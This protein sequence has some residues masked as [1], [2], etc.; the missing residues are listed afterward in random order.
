MALPKMQAGYMSEKVVG[1]KYQGV[2]LGMTIPLW[3]NKNQVKFA[4]A[5]VLAVQEMETDVKVILYNQ[6]KGL[7]AK[8]DGLR[9][10][11]ADYRLQ[12]ERFS[13]T[14]LLR[15]AL[16]KGEISLAEYIFELSQF[17]EG[18][19]NLLAMERDLNVTLVELYQ[20]Q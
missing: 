15:K 2:T 9:S 8:A 12:L 11:L 16:E 4:K 10:N 13:S 18:V 20:Y 17:Y 7:Y 19:D 6:L 1:L 14:A 5:K 3:E